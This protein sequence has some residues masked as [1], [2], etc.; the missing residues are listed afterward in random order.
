ME[1]FKSLTNKIKS[2]DERTIESIFIGNI[3]NN[4]TCNEETPEIRPFQTPK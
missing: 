1:L 3:E 2:Y 4:P